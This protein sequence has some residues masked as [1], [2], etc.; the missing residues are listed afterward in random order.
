MVLIFG[1]LV[2][3]TGSHGDGDFGS[4]ND[5]SPCYQVE[6]IHGIACYPID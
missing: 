5:C 2:E 1:K 6:V 3:K 4:R